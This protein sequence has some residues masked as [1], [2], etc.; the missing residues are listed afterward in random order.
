[1][2]RLIPTIKEI[3]AG[4]RAKTRLFTRN[5]ERYNIGSRPIKMP[6][7]NYEVRHN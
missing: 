1:M 2:N 7:R 5:K 4:S 3:Q 6:E